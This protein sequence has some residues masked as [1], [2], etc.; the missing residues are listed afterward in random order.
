MTPANY[1]ENGSHLCDHL[2]DLLDLRKTGLEILDVKINGDYN[3]G[4]NTFTIQC[5]FNSEQ[6]DRLQ[7]A[8]EFLAAL[9]RKP[10]KEAGTRSINLE[11]NE[12]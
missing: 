8:T 3:S 11:G 9:D 4:L 2:V 1:S 10:T 5:A 6:L 7:K 12:E